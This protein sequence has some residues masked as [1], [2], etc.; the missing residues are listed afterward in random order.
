[1]KIV[2]YIIFILLIVVIGALVYV[3][4]YPS[5]YDISRSKVIKAPVS[6]VYNIVNE[7]R[8]WEQWGP[9]HDEDSTIV[10][11]YGNIT[12]GVGAYNSWTSKD[13]P[14]NMKT[15]NV[16]QNERIEQKMQFGDFEPSDVIWKFKEVDGATEVTWQMKE[17]SAPFIFKMFAAFTGGWDAML[18]TM[19]ARGLENLEKV[20]E[21]Q[22]KIENSYRLS[23]VEVINFEGKTFIGYYHKAKIGDINEMMKLFEADIPKAGAHALKNNLKYTD[24]VPAS[25]YQKWDQKTGE[26]EFYIGVLLQKDIKA[27]K[28]MSKIKLP[29]GSAAIISKFGKY[30]I[31]DQKAHIA[32]DKY[33]SANK[34]N[35]AWPIWELYVNDPQTVMP[36]D[37]QTDI[38]YSIK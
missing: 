23:E 34:L 4:F 21:E 15:V 26:T 7:M 28:G 30:G 27:A 32:I 12:S 11:T 35:K 31:G 5:D 1:M 22:L 33:M 8:T 2:K 18:G 14:G 13:G 9:W 3:G 37:I 6:N 36:Q 25:V 29:K 24:F 38:Y 17:K 20:V 10:V 19:E 16:I